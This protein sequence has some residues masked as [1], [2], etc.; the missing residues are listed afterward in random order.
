MPQQKQKKTRSVSKGRSAPT[1]AQPTAAPPEPPATSPC[2][3]GE[4]GRPSGVTTTF[5]AGK[6]LEA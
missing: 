2:A 4:T 1:V 3:A 6:D 5:K